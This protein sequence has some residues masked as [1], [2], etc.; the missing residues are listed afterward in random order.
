MKR[1]LVWGLAALF[2]VGCGRSEEE[3]LSGIVEVRE[4]R[5][6]FEEPGT[7][8]AVAVDVGDAVEK[9]GEVA[10][11][12][13]RELAIAL[14][15]ARYELKKARADLQNLLNTPRPEALTAARAREKAAAALL[16]NASDE[17]E[18]SRKLYEKG[19]ATDQSY[20]QRETEFKQAR[21]VHGAAKADREL[22]EAGSKEEAV[23]AQEMQIAA[24]EKSVELLEVRLEKYRLH[25]PVS[26]RVLTR[27]FEPGEY[28]RAG[29]SVVTVADPEDCWVVVY[30]PEASYG[31]IATGQQVEVRFDVDSVGSVKGNIREIAEEASFAP[32]MNLRK[33]QRSDLYFRVEVR[34]DN[35]RH[36]LKPGMIADVFLR[37]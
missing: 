20:R 34:L 37:R 31:E 7:L 28:V 21:E 33:E 25:T 12:D 6:A 11:L 29:Q 30:V 23:A 22:L 9:G 19:V 18:R 4:V 26:G 14:E 3:V 13:G 2:I 5:L 35:R 15:R 24:L 1:A 32:R 36:L 10:R 17:F 16:Q 27:N 8:E